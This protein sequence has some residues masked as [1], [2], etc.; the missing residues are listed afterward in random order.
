MAYLYQMHTA[1]YAE[2]V[3]FNKS[4]KQIYILPLQIQ[5]LPSKYPFFS[6]PVHRIFKRK[7]LRKIKHISSISFVKSIRSILSC[8]VHILTFSTDYI[9]IWQS[10][11]GSWCLTLFYTFSQRYLFGKEQDIAT[12][13]LEQQFRVLLLFFLMLFLPSF[14]VSHMS[15]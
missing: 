11:N 2:L 9:L 15:S 7:D 10:M 14:F 5:L 13:E 1:V 4:H 8:Y 3:N 6:S 12:D